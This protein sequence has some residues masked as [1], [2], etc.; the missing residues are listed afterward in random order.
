MRL[1]R[2]VSPDTGATSTLPTV[3]LS[4]R[5]KRSG[6][7]ALAGYGVGGIAI[8][9]AVGGHWLAA[10]VAASAALVL[11]SQSAIV[12]LPGTAAASRRRINDVMID[13]RT[14]SDAAWTHAP[15]RSRLVARLAALDPPEV[16]EPLH[17]RLLERLSPETDRRDDDFGSATRAARSVRTWTEIRQL[18]AEMAVLA[19]GTD[20]GA[21]YQA[22]L[23]ESLDGWWS[24][25]ATSAGR[26]QD[27]ATRAVERLRR[28]RR[29]NRMA[30]AHVGLID[31]M[32]AYSATL[33]ELRAALEDDHDEEAA[34]R[35]GD[36]LD[37][38]LRR[39][40]ARWQALAVV[41]H[42]RAG[43]D[44]DAGSSRR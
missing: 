18:M 8:L 30:E 43:G 31:A 39:L 38:A 28:I 7:L 15:E 12:T 36:R 33:A 9:F 26:A 34:A 20:R 40:L 42:K 11:L 1:G 17:A 13:W 24:D 16:I 19:P 23:G 10:L 2:R 3:T 44:A 29:S 25:Y 27:A 22:R 14:T 41:E 6:A 21:A 32:Q 5:L 37:E 35:A 4:S